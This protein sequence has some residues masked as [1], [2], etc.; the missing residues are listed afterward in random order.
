MGSNCC[1]NVRVAGISQPEPVNT[2]NSEEQYKQSIISVPLPMPI[3]LDT[4]K[5]HAQSNSTNP[6]Q[7]L[8]SIN[9]DINNKITSQLHLREALNE[10]DQV[11]VPKVV[12]SS[13]FP[14]IRQKKKNS[15][16]EQQESAHSG[17]A[18]PKK[19]V[20]E[21]THSQTITVR[22]PSLQKIIKVNNDNNLVESV[23]D[24]SYSE[25]DQK[26]DD[27]WRLLAAPDRAGFYE[28]ERFFTSTPIP[29]SS[30]HSDSD[31]E[32]SKSLNHF[33]RPTSNNI[34]SDDEH[35]SAPLSLMQI[36]RLREQISLD[37]YFKPK[38]IPELQ[39][40]LQHLYSMTE[41][42]DF[43]SKKL[44]NFDCKISPNNSFEESTIYLSDTAVVVN[45]KKD[46]NNELDVVHPEAFNEAFNVKRQHVIDNSSYRLIIE[47]WRPTSIE[48]LI[49]QIKNV[50]KN[51]PTIDRLWIVFYWIARN[52]EY[53]TV[54]YVGKKHVDKSAEAV[55]RTGKAVADGYANL[56]K[57]LCSAL[58][59]SCEK[60]HGY[61]KA[62]VFDPSN[63]SSVPIDHTWNAVQINQHWYLID[64][65]CSAGY[66]DSNLVF[67]RELNSYYFLPRSN[68]MIYH[69][70]P[71]NE[72]WQLLKQPIKMMQYMQVPKLW[73]KFFQLNLQ[74][75][76]P[77]DIIHVD[78][79]PRQPYA[80][81]LIQAPRRISLIANFTLNENEIDGG[82]QIVFDSQK[83][84][85]RCYFAPSSIGVHIISFF[86]KDDS[87]SNSSYSHVAELELDIRQM[88][89]KPISFPKTWK[90]FFEL[91]LGIIWP[92]NT[93][94][95]KMNHGDTHTE[96]I[97]RAPSDVELTSRLTID[98]SIKIPGGNC[99]FF[100]R[101]KGIWRCMFA[102]HR[103]GLFEAYIMAKRRLDPGSFA[104]AARFK[105]K[106]KR[107][108]K[109]PLSYPK[110]W[111]LFYDLDLQVETPRNSA[112]VMWPEYGSYAQICM[113]AP[114]DV[115]LMCCIE[116][117]SNRI[118]NGALTQ[119]NNE[120]Q[121]WQ[122]FF[123]PERAGKHKLLV[124]AQCS[125]P[126]GVI[127][128]IAVEFHLDVT[129]LRHPIKFPVTYTTF[130]S[131]KCRIHEP[132][133]GILKRGAVVCIHC[134]IPNAKQVDLTIDSKWVKSEGYRDSILKR[135]II[136]GSKEVIIYAKYD[137]NT[138]YNELIKYTVQ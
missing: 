30:E 111:Q 124:F 101:R 54:P 9:P 126:D 67:K 85:Y 138:I 86:A 95:I 36:L 56:F 29:A 114:D 70:F 82:H 92:C 64:L 118:E 37:E 51:K 105:I 69:H 74:L 46:T 120:K 109:P 127:S 23:S 73:P 88:P 13:Q 136:V 77:S 66:L 47:A 27:D 16:N 20:I 102:P 71:T 41:T 96:I 22:L 50:S 62:Y 34:G 103:D 2:N 76:H 84:L 19:T 11:E 12:T 25:S 91:N 112:T 43:P 3:E 79:V 38:P 57:H 98:S 42:V 106:A 117:N 93:H 99:T 104:V 65:T 72:L 100:D 59:L 15:E 131:K 7:H 134:E 63:R 115:R 75:I 108:P 87:T 55:F 94:L 135:Q 14:P 31:E 89:L 107:I 40:S 58:D 35:T 119:F 60:V 121:H 116:Q 68:E 78:L 97:I 52:I 32:H 33:I 1:K 48:Q 18:V 24:E 45:D 21:E 83:R 81:V 130:L 133:D 132:L 10:N 123:A 128:G 61:S 8:N 113:K 6:S 5:K 17:Q 80:I 28:E 125:T 122:L 90:T 49:D 26:V 129:Q 53:D 39:L 110:T 137:E 44:Q 4:D